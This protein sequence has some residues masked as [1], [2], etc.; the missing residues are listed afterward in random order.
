MIDDDYVF[1][2]LAQEAKETKVQLE[3]MLLTDSAAWTDGSLLSPQPSNCST[4]QESSEQN[5]G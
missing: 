1:Q 5:R 2:L 4:P 3:V